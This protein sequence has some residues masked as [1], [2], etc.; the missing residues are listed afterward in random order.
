M[1]T[2]EMPDRGEKAAAAVASVVA[3]WWFPSLLLVLIG[4]WVVVNLIFRPM[5]PFPVIM[6]AF[7]S[8]V[9]ASLSALQGPLILLAQRRARMRDQELE[10]EIHRIVAHNEADMHQ[11]RLRLDQLWEEMV[12][13]DE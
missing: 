12:S 9:L 5:E 7:I 2:E 13:E 6:L 3:T 8:A 4:V 11:I 1:L 10:R